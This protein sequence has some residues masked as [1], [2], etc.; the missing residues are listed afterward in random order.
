[1]RWLSLAGR[2]APHWQGLACRTPAI[3]ALYWC[4]RCWDCS[5]SFTWL[6]FR[7]YDLNTLC[8]FSPPRSALLGIIPPELGEMKALEEIR[9]DNLGLEGELSRP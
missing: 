7:V 1:M 6:I 3:V 9:L 8:C 2:R 5:I 4:N